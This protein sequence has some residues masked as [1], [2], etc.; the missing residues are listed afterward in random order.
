MLIARNFLV[1]Y[2]QK[3]L[4]LVKALNG[5]LGQVVRFDP[6]KKC[7]MIFVPDLDENGFNSEF[8]LR[9]YSRQPSKWRRIRKSLKSSDGLALE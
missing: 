8:L 9:T 2:W 4:I 6:A 7:Y 5:K 3:G 1:F